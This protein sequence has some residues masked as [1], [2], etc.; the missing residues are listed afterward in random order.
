MWAE[1]SS[2][3]PRWRRQEGEGARA[4]PGVAETAVDGLAE[5]AAAA[6]GWVGGGM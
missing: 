6:R 4:P 3:V 1:P 2:A 5:A